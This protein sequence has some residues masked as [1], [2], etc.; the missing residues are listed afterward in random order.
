MGPEGGEIDLVA[1]GKTT[2]Y[3]IISYQSSSFWEGNPGMY[4][5]SGRLEAPG[6]CEGRLVPSKD[7]AQWSAALNSKK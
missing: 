5:T 6:I 7:I 1:A 4:T 2:A 3:H